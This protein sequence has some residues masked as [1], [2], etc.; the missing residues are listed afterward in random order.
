MGKFLNPERVDNS[1]HIGYGDK[2]FS[3]VLEVGSL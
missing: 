2:K 3:R 1:Q